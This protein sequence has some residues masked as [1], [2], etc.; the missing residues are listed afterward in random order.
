M[1]ARP[2]SRPRSSTATPVEM[3]VRAAGSCTSTLAPAGPASTSPISPPS[4]AAPPPPG[5][6][7]TARGGGR[8][9]PHRSRQPPRRGGV[10]RACSAARRRPRLGRSRC[11]SSPRRLDT[12]GAVDV[13]LFRLALDDATSAPR[14]RSGSASGGAYDRT[15]GGRAT[16][17]VRG[18]C[19]PGGALQE[20]EDCIPAYYRARRA[21]RSDASHNLS[22][23]ARRKVEFIK[24]F[25]P[26]WLALVLLGALNWA[27]VALFD[28][29]V[30][31]EILGTGTATDVVYVSWAS[32]P[33][34]SCRGARGHAPR[35]SRPP[36]RRLSAIRGGPGVHTRP[37]G[38]AQGS[39][40]DGLMREKLRC[41]ADRWLSPSCASAS[42]TR[43]RR[44]CPTC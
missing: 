3:R 23:S 16:S 5:G 13:R 34:H 41:Y 6:G 43:S 39:T 12:D 21:S 42:R 7:A 27:L 18:R 28:F 22:P 31:E 2:G 19:A 20:R 35:R 9:R 33:W 10:A 26:V 38:L 15:A 44:S 29:N 36:A 14:P 11:A 8:A 25:E 24:R 17:C 4:C 40:L 32:R 30:V 1:A 37:I